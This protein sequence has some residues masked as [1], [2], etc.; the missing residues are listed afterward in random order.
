ML[1]TFDDIGKWTAVNGEGIYGSRPWK[2]F[3][4][5]PAS[6][7]TVKAGNFNED[8]IKYTAEDVRFTTNGNKLYAFLLDVPGGDIRIRSLG[9][10]SRLNMLPIREIK[11]LGS[12]GKIQWR[13][14]EDALII[15]KPAIMPDWKVVGLRIE[16]AS[17]SLHP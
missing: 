9:K 1:K 4:E 2:I 17:G 15:S 11:L 6:A 14:E 16:F 12:S 10:A 7:M 8:H 5:R 13:Q 3:G